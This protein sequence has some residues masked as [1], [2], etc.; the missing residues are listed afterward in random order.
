[1]L[2]PSSKAFLTL[3]W[4]CP[5]NFDELNGF[6]TVTEVPASLQSFKGKKAPIDVEN[7]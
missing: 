5:N 6:V 4:N 1:M 7:I 3:N 2:Y